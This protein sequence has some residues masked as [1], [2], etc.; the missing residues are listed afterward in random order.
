LL[1]R[2]ILLSSTTLQNNL[3][4]SN[5]HLTLSRQEILS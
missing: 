5:I 1:L 2:P 3:Q 4:F